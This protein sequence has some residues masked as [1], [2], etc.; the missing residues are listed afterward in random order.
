MLSD[1]WF[2][3]HP[4]CLCL[5]CFQASVHLMFGE[6]KARF[7]AQVA[8][9][10]SKTKVERVLSSVCVLMCVTVCVC[11]S[12]IC[13]HVRVTVYASCT[14][15]HCMYLIVCV[16]LCVYVMLCVCTHTSHVHTCMLVLEKSP[17]VTL[18][19]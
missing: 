11:V 2:T 5:L 16:S 7:G 1:S 15:S 10:K 19:S 12:L 8:V 13:V 18:C 9:V 6:D 3:I 4:D 14:V 17:E